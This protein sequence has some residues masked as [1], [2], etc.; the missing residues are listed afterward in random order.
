MSEISLYSSYDRYAWGGFS[1]G[2]RMHR[3]NNENIEIP[4]DKFQEQNGLRKHY[5]ICPYC[6]SIITVTNLTDTYIYDEDGD[7]TIYQCNECGYWISSINI[8]DFQSS[9]TKTAFSVQK[10]FPIKSKNIPIDELAAFLKNKSHLT[11]YLHHQTFEK[12]TGEL[13]KVEYGAYEV[14]HVGKV[15]DRGIDV[16]LIVSENEKILVQCK[17]RLKDGAVES[18]ST[19]KLLL[20]T[21]VEHRSLKGI[22]FSNADYFSYHAIKLT[23]NANVND[24]GYEIKLYDKSVLNLL[25]DKYPTTPPWDAFFKNEL[26][27]TGIAKAHPEESGSHRW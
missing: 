21:L 14:I 3:W 6:N 15:A 22:V 23:Q 16:I 8:C 4:W 9:F 17:R 20:G 18:V 1:V 2:P 27:G 25:L 11:K 7:C 24:A 13:L 19:V 26:K 10:R 12:L 5:E